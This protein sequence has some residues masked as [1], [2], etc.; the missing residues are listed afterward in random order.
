MSTMPFDPFV[1]ERGL[2]WRNRVAR[3]RRE[4]GQTAAHAIAL[5]L[6][7]LLLLP[8]LSDAAHSLAPLARTALREWPGAISFATLA[9]IAWRQARRR[10]ALLH[11]ESREW[12]VAQPVTDAVRRRRHDRS[13]AVE[14][15]VQALA[16]ATLLWLVQAPVPALAVLLVLVAAAALTAPWLA[17]RLV[18][19]EARAQRLGSRLGDRGRGR[20]WR[21][22]RIETA[23]AL[24]GRKLGYG[25]W[26]LLL[27]PMGSGPFVVL[28]TLAAGLG[29]AMLITA[30]TR[31]LAVLPQAQAWL[32]AEPITGRRMLAASNGVPCAILLLAVAMLGLVLVALGTPGLALAVAMAI[33]ALGALQF[34]CGFAWRAQPRRIAL[35]Q[36]LH[37]ALLLSLLQAF[38]PLV[39]P[40]WVLQ[41]LWL[42][43]RGMRP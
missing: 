43:R 42:L 26:A 31:A 18:A 10:H 21:W 29:L 30:W 16:G 36:V 39:L 27:V 20:V 1:A 34:A 23:V 7:A 41:M 37:I 3:W 24:R 6:L 22:Q 38:A 32:Q 28:A 19:H 9:L 17:R 2:R 15:I 4:A 8:L 13:R 35:Q 40:L 25:L 5:L 14:A 12:W 33:A 11:F